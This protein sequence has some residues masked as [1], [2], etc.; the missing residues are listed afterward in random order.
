MKLLVPIV[1]ALSFLNNFFHNYYE[2]SY[3]KNVLTTS[4]CAEIEKVK[5][6][7]DEELIDTAIYKGAFKIKEN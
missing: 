5:K 6:K 3:L 7:V 4:H 2:I 1:D